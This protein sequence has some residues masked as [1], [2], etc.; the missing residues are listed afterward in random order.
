M[1][2]TLELKDFE[3][4]VKPLKWAKWDNFSDHNKMVEMSV[5]TK[6]RCIQAIWTLLDISLVQC[7]V[8]EGYK[9]N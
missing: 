2:D 8:F 3:D 1:E 4:S 9:R 6:Q 7:C 5:Q